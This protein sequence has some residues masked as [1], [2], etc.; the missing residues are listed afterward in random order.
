M[1]KYLFIMCLTIVCVQLTNA[2]NIIFTEK[3]ESHKEVVS[4]W[5][6]ASNLGC[7]V[8]NNMLFMRYLGDS[9][10]S[11]YLACTLKQTLDTKDSYILE[12]DVK[13]IQ[14][15]GN[16]CGIKLDGISFLIMKN[17]FHYTYVEKNKKRT[18]AVFHRRI[19]KDKIYKFKIV[20]NKNSYKWF[21]NDKWLTSFTTEEAM[22]PKSFLKL[23]TYGMEVG[24]SN[25]KIYQTKSKNGN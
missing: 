18:S 8:E 21:V 22:V 7:A 25:L 12:I 24:F 1:L 23:V 4:R 15:D 10:T 3:F 2:S 13:A 6:N 5:K 20:K 17:A 9:T 16:W 14:L 19:K 11:Q